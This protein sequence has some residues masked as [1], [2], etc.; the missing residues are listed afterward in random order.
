MSV[1]ELPYNISSPE[2][3]FQTSLRIILAS[4]RNITKSIGELRDELR[5]DLTNSKERIQTMSN[6]MVAQIQN[7]KLQMKPQAVPVSDISLYKVTPQKIF[8]LSDLALYL[9]PFQ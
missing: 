3:T 4:L 2:E 1:P 9:D 6:S 7:F 5:S 8:A